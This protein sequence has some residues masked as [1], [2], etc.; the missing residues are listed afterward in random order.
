MNSSRA[1][2][3]SKLASLLRLLATSPAEFGDRLRTI[4]ESK[5]APLQRGATTAPVS[6]EVLIQQLDARL[7]GA[8]SRFLKD[9]QLKELDA[10]L[11]RGLEKLTSAPTIELFHNPGALLPRMCYALCRTLRPR[12]VVE[13]GVAYGVTSTFMLRALASNGAGELWSIDLPPLSARA[14]SPIGPLVPAELRFR[15][16]VLRG[17]SRRM[18]PQL[19]AGLPAIDI[20]LHDSL[21]TYG[22]MTREFET[23]WPK[24]RPGGFL[25]SDDVELNRSFEDFSAAHAVDFALTASET[26]KASAFG[27]MIKSAE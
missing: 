27:V 3:P 23:V 24:L 12:V 7:K 17:V 22:N 14:N 6:A 15:W 26:N 16:H 13:T 1:M 5:A 19:V 9:P 25:L 21:H 4:A 8:V 20:F 2:Q 10:L 18:L 11:A